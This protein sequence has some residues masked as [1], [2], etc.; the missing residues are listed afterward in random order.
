M[1]YDRKHLQEV[2]QCI[3]GIETY[4]VLGRG[5]FD[6]DELVRCW[7]RLKLQDIGSASS[8]VSM[9]MRRSHPDLPWTQMTDFRNLL[10]NYF[11]VDYEAIWRVIDIDLAPMKT[12]VQELLKKLP[13]DGG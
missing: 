6:Q 4:A 5:R 9:D 3:G 12:K 1:Q 10:I 11:R 13:P 2:L 8:R 7:M